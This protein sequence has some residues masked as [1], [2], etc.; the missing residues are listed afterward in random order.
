MD[1]H[2][3]RRAMTPAREATRE[4]ADW[5]LLAR[6]WAYAALTRLLKHVIPLPR[7]VALAVTGV[8]ARTREHHVQR[9]RRLVDGAAEG[10]VRLPGNCLDRSV[11]LFRLLVACG[12]SPRLVI[13]MRPGSAPGVEG[14][15]WV[16][17][18]GEDLGEPPDVTSGFA[19]VLAFDAS[20]RSQG[21]SAPSPGLAR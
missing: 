19:Q 6:I 20:G 9:L 10:R 8:R 7:L 2:L 4:R 17:L 3:T 16:S 5:A 1:G 14:H 11:P 15:V 21:P 12:A 18:D 13:G